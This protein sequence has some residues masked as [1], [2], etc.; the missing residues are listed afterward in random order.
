[1]LLTKWIV[2]KTR[3]SL[4]SVLRC[5]GQQY[6]VVSGG[7]TVNRLD[8]MIIWLQFFVV[9]TFLLYYRRRT[10][11]L[12][13]STKLIQTF[14]ICFHVIIFS[15]LSASSST[16]KC[17][18]VKETNVEHQVSFSEQSI[19]TNCQP[20]IKKYQYL[21]RKLY[22]FVRGL[23]KTKHFYSSELFLQEACTRVLWDNR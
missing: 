15:T 12:Q 13:H 14:L 5:N 21:I 7:R 16:K 20:K 18:K 3:R 19:F 10:I 11:P 4:Y 6:C 23:F 2:T 17:H 9:F 8:Y 1:M 22:S